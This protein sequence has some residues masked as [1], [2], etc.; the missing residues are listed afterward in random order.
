LLSGDHVLP[1]ITPHISGLGADPDPLASFFR[2]LDLCAALEGV[3]KT[4]PAHGHPFDDLPGRVKAIKE[5]HAE[6]IAMLRAASAE[7]GWA[8]VVDLSKKIFQPRVWGSMAESETFA[9][10]EH[11]VQLGEA[12]RRGSEATLEY[13]LN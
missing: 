1:T 10:L 9:H 6:R 11:L 5:H 2:S 7:L 13:L 3:T 4:L 12:E 8:N